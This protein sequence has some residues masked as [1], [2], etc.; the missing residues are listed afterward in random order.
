MKVSVE[1]GSYREHQCPVLV[2]GCHEGN[3]SRDRV[4]ADLDDSL[5]GTIGLLARDREFSG[6]LNTV[7]LLHTC[8]RLPAERLLLVGLGQEG[9]L[10]AERL[11]QA[12]GTAARTLKAA[13]LGRFTSILHQTAVSLPDAVPA[14][15][16]GLLLGGYSFDRYKTAPLEEGPLLEATVLCADPAVLDDCSKTVK[17]VETVCAAVAMARD[18]V[19]QP[20]NVATPAYL[21]E[22]ALEV[23]SRLGIDCRVL[24][25]D[26][27]ERL[28]M[29]GLIAVGQGAHHP[30]RFI[31]MEYNAA[32][33][34]TRPIV[35]VGKGVTFDSGGIS[36]K[37]RD[38]MERM[39][40]D[41][42]GAA[43][44]MATLMAVAGLKLPLNVVGLVPAAENLPGG[45]A[46]KPGD[47]IR[48]M[49]GRT[50]EIVNTDAEG[51][52]LLADA[53]CYAERY[54]PAALIDLA[55]L[56]GACLVSLGTAAS[57]LLGNNPA[58]LQELKRAGETTGERLWEL[59]LWDEYGE[60]MKSEVADLKNAGGSSAGTITAAWFLS[61]FVGKTR[62]A[63]L[64][65]AGTAWEEK[66]RSYQP[67]GATGVGVRLLVEYLRKK[68]AK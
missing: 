52:M 59:P 21:A 5:A 45:G 40:D 20:G 30:P 67:K 46:Y 53:L 6:K 66:G 7:K 17:D 44:V 23:S 55:T 57:G 50:V 47:I 43:A 38:G 65:I 62:W 48:T 60:L 56:T 11:R 13:G 8:G 42:A 61:R 25:C 14:T 24:E 22:R 18:L 54:R 1:T 29:G 19:S 9:L 34:G 39:K 10:T 68:A 63:H 33:A 64:D 12:A 2:V 3:P 16:E 35:L 26:D 4:V 41:M 31:I 37:P 36:L 15:V 51:R 58:L 49:S 28:A 32:P 27:L